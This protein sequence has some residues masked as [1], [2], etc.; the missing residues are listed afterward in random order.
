MTEFGGSSGNVLGRWMY[1]PCTAVHI[2]E[3]SGQEAGMGRV[4]GHSQW[5]TIQRIV[6]D[7]LH[8][9]LRPLYKWLF[10]KRDS[11]SFCTDWYGVFRVEERCRPVTVRPA[12]RQWDERANEK[13][14]E[15]ATFS[16]WRTAC[17]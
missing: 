9:L 12:W 17:Y 2:A 3:R 6:L 8:Y 15:S 5:A 16:A 1:K 11:E 13:W 14:G 7:G 4:F 10:R